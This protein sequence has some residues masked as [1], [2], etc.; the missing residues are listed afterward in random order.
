MVSTD[1]VIDVGGVAV[2]V[3]AD[4]AYS[5]FATDRI[6][7]LRSAEPPTIVLRLGPDQPA[8]PERDPDQ[9]LE[10]IDSWSEGNDLWMKL[11]NAVTLVSGNE[12]IVG[13]SID[14]GAGYKSIDLM[15]QF[16]LAAAMASPDRIMVHG[17]VV[18]KNDEAL[19]VVGKSGRGKSTAATA[20]MANGWE[21]LT[22][23]LAVAHPVKRRVRGVARPP[24][25]PADL[26]SSYGIEGRLEL[27]ERGRLI[28]D[29]ETLARGDRRLAGLVQVD[30]GDSG[31]LT[32]VQQA[33]LHAIDDALAVP[34]FGPVM[35]RHL[36]S[37][38][39]LVS[40]PTFQLQHA[41]DETI[42]A[43]RAV[44]LL[45]EALRLAVEG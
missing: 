20:A 13:G 3:V 31:S 22:D 14:G 38:A 45:D 26:A 17:A 25:I 24:R 4:P 23:D 11:G 43:D 5:V 8:P 21:L 27:G 37:A 33:D 29:V 39:A 18:A 42:R 44:E 2:S 15:V 36:V 9:H 41:A 16:G 19:L 10:M 12:V 40:I 6:G 28:L 34:P 7:S 32:R 1:M 30:H 35:R